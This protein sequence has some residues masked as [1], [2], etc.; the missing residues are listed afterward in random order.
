MESP[1]CITT[2]TPTGADTLG[3]RRRPALS[4]SPRCG[5]R[6][7]ESVPRYHRD[8]GRGATSVG[9]SDGTSRVLV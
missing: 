4:A 9:E 6:G 7:L 8:G 3:L 2:G 1:G 5:T